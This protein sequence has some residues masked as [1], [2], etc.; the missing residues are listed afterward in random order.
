MEIIKNT[1]LMQAT[2][3]S[4]RFDNKSI[5][6]VPTMG[7]LHEGHLSLVKRAIDEND[8]S[9]VSIFVNPFQFGPKED[10]N[11]YPRDLLVDLKKLEDIDNGIVFIPDIKDIYNDGFQSFVEV[12][13]ITEKMCGLFRP[14][15]FRGVTTVVAKLF[16]IVNP[17]RAYF[18]QKDFQQ[19]V[20]I[21]KMVIGLN[22]DLEVVTCPTVRES[23]G[24]AM[25]SRNVYMSPVEREDV[26]LIY[27]GMK[28]I[29]EEL[30]KGKTS[31]KKAKKILNNILKKGKSIK[32]IQ[33]ASLY[34]P[35]TLDDITDIDIDN[36]KKDSVLI[37]VALKIGDTRLIDNLLVNLK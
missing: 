35:E 4:Y 2:S 25:S 26:S 10:F 5:G 24:L 36:Y 23:D 9:V 1:A 7:A 22:F 14:G 11:K 12:K 29:E 16:N 33:Y 13:G 15:H 3:K 31:F 19:S 32:E 8:I 18:G 28:T 30:I 21:K 20:V 34:D 6:F 27:K 17:N 37:A